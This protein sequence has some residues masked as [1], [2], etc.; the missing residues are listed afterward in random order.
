MFIRNDEQFQAQ[1]LEN[2]ITIDFHNIEF[3][4]PQ[5]KKYGAKSNNKPIN[6]ITGI[7]SENLK[8]NL[9]AK[10]KTS[11]FPFSTPKSLKSVQDYAEVSGNQ[12]DAYKAGPFSSQKYQGM[13]DIKFNL[14]FTTYADVEYM[15]GYSMKLSKPL[16][17]LY[18]LM[19][20]QLPKEGR[21]STE[22]MMKQLAGAIDGASEA[23]S[24]VINYIENVIDGKANPLKD[25][26]FKSL[27]NRMAELNATPGNWITQI[28][29]GNLF[30]GCFVIENLNATISN[31]KYSD[32]SPLYITFELS[33]KNYMVPDKAAIVETEGDIVSYK[34]NDADK[35]RTEISEFSRMYITNGNRA[36]KLQRE[37][38]NKG[39]FVLNRKLVN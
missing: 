2:L 34:G 6:T 22:Q 7:M 26:S 27:D 8:L 5:N 33:I 13:E 39:A 19:I 9:Q 29:L 36:T 31:E 15:L 20:N 17:A 30:K 12:Q 3:G 28:T 25:I 35:L 1:A 21:G 24:Q 38:M 37:V 23:G 32:G 14:K 10:W 4:I 11:S 16:E 18:W